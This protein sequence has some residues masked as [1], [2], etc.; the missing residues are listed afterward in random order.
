MLYC[1]WFSSLY[2]LIVFYRVWTVP[3]IIYGCR[4]LFCLVYWCD[5][6]PGYSVVYP[7]VWLLELIPFSWII[8]TR[9]A[10]VAFK[11]LVLLVLQISIPLEK[12]LFLTNWPVLKIIAG[13]F[14]EVVCPLFADTLPLWPL[15]SSSEVFFGRPSLPS[16]PWESI[17]TLCLSREVASV[18]LLFLASR[19]LTLTWL[20]LV[21]DLYWLKAPIDVYLPWVP[22]V[23]RLKR[24]FGM[25]LPLTA[26]V[27]TAGWLKFWVL[28]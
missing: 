11:E 23:A 6:I 16:E 4:W 9:V 14:T 10:L 7:D 2:C 1:Y 12:L 28:C 18:W 8:L 24:A 25:F 26:E 17:P 27:I 19:R 13:G 3:V 15:S 22:P 5:I 21:D 20:L